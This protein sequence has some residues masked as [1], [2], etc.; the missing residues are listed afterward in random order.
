VIRTVLKNFK[1]KKVG[2]IGD[3]MIDEYIKGNVERISP[4]APVPVVEAK[5]STYSPGG[6]GN[7][8]ANL[9]SLGAEVVVFG[10][11]GT[12]K[13]G[14]KLK[15]LLEKLGANVEFLVEDDSRPTTIKTR[16]IAGSQQLLRIDWESREEVKGEVAEKI[17]S[18]LEDTA[19]D[20]DALVISDYGKGVVIDRLFEITKKLKEKL[21][22]LLDPKEKNYPIYRHVTT[23]TPNIKETFQ[24]VGIKPESDELAKIA[25]EELIRKF[26]LDFA[27]ITRSEQGLSVVGKDFIHHIPARAKQVFDVTGAGD[28]VISVMALA[29]ASG[30]SPEEAG[31]LANIAG[32][33]VVGKL[34]TAVVSVE[35]IERELDEV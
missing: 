25:G 9:I 8:V 1:G 29:L 14:A 11:V 6:A 24:A 3:F 7:V 5:N 20:F 17:Y 34:G 26:K 35:E 19:E 32:G 28:T 30:A 22:V 4:E 2:V 16:I 31:Y 27:V 33:I 13:N 15:E 10:V 18:A 21:P 12:D 23:M